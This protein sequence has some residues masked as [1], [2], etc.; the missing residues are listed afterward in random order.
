MKK[1]KASWRRDCII[2]IEIL[3]SKRI[4]DIVFAI[5]KTKENDLLEKYLKSLKV[6]VLGVRKMMF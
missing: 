4:N 5:P 3:K 1:V 2:I 6:K